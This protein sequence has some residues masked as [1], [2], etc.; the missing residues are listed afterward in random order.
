MKNKKI[1]RIWGGLGNQIFQYAFGQFLEKEQNC[2][3]SFNINWFNGQSKRK[4]IL[5]K[6]FKITNEIID[7][8]NNF[9]DKLLN[10]KT[11]KFYK[12]LIKKNFLFLPKNLIGYWQD[13]Y[14]AKYVNKENFLREFFESSENKKNEK[15]Y[16]L[17][18]RGGDFYNSKDH[19]VLDLEYY[20]K[21]IDFFR[22]EKIYCLS[23]D[24][25]QLEL[26][27]NELNL[28]NIIIPNLNELDSFRLICNSD[29]GIASNSTFCWWAA[30]I[31]GNKN[32][33][34]PK[35]WLKN[36]TLISE[37]LYIDDTLLL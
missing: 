21:S 7:E 30:Y 15:Y 11:E 12:T 33:V 16:I 22:N 20:K 13:L 2:K 31:S 23:D 19:L 26:L 18:F 25:K 28:K 34:F 24:N 29:G 27:V 10:Y 17:H 4:F 9:I 35:K 3:I 32:W 6:I 5:D 1:I 36:K 8:E 14:F 37:N